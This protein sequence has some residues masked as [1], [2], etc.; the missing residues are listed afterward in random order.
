MVNL[1]VTLIH[2][3]TIMVSSS[4]PGLEEGRVAIA[5]TL[6]KGYDLDYI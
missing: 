2:H 4:I 3:L 6:S 1:N 5:A